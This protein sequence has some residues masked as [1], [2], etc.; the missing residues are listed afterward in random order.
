MTRRGILS[1]RR[2][3]QWIC[4]LTDVSRVCILC[5]ADNF[6]QPPIRGC[7]VVELLA[8][9]ILARPEPTRHCFVDDRHACAIKL[10][11]IASPQN[12]YSHR[13]EIIRTDEVPIACT[14]SLRGLLLAR[15]RNDI[16]SDSHAVHRHING[17][18][19]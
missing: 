10:A 13:L 1:E 16:K 3:Q 14:P 5:D 9:G 4:W 11:E 7:A 6:Q 2:V 17:K 8:D 19:C 15:Y 12:R 18:T